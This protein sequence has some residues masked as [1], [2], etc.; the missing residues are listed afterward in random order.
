MR[1]SPTHSEW[2][3]LF[4]RHVVPW[5]VCPTQC[6]PQWS[7]PAIFHPG[8]L[9]RPASRVAG[10]H[11][12]RLRQ[13]AQRLVRCRRSCG[14]RCCW[15]V[16]LWDDDEPEKREGEALFAFRFPIAVNNLGEID[17]QRGTHECALRIVQAKAVRGFP[18]SVVA[19][20]DTR[21]LDQAVD[22]LQ[23]DRHARLCPTAFRG[24]AGAAG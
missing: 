3:S 14:S 6:S 23:Q 24:L 13:A 20:G 17:F 15:G 18:G 9:C 12:L 2:G 8:A 1:R 7:Q 16:V 10:R 4:G 22:R 11:H 21:H 19:I 5:E